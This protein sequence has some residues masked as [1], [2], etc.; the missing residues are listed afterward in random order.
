MKPSDF[1]ARRATIEDLEGLREL[2]RAERLPAS[3]LE[4]Q[5]NEFQLAQGPDGRIMAAMALR[6]EGRHG[7][8]HTEA[9]L[10]FAT[11]DVLRPLL[12]ERLQ[13]IA[14]NRGLFRLWTT[15]TVLFWRERGFDPPSPELLEKKP[16][17]LGEADA[18][19]LTLKLKED[20]LGDLTPEQ[21]LALFK[22]ALRA[23]SEKALGQARVLKWIATVAA[24]AFLLLV[25][26]A[27]VY[28]IRYQH[29][30]E[31]GRLP[32]VTAKPASSTPK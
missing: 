13:T 12:W 30:K 17:K 21:E 28:F 19:W 1:Q 18:P 10:D 11:V 4:K 22:D 5:L 16:A 2:W 23:D 24:F 7:M 25:I 14:R 8:I 15:E 20:I 27:F 31:Q 26:T 32:A 29:A 9:Y 6:V 3:V